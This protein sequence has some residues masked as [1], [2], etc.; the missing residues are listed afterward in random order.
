MSERS[1]RNGSSLSR[2]RFLEISLGAVVAGSLGCS[3]DDL[4]GNNSSIA[5]PKSSTHCSTG[6]TSLEELGEVVSTDVLI[7]GGG[8]GGLVA[9]VKAKETNPN[10]DVLIVEKQTTGWAGKASKIGGVVAFLGP[11]NDADKFL[12]FQIRTCGRY[13]NNQQLLTKYVQETYRAVAQLGDWGVALGRGQ[14]GGL[15]SLPNPFALEYSMGLIDIDLMLS[16]R[17]RALDLKARVLNKI[18]VTDLVKQADRIVGAVGFSILTGRFYTIK[19]KATVLANGSCGY[20]VRRFWVAGTGDGVAAAFRAGAEMRN[21]EY[22]NLYGHVVYQD[23]DSGMVDTTTLV[24]AQGEGL[25]SKYVSNTGPSGVFVPVELA[26]GLEKEVLEGKGPIYSAPL[27]SA[28][29]GE[30]NAGTGLPKITDWMQRMAAKEAKYGPPLD[31]KRAL[32]LPL[33]AETSCIKVDPEM[34]TSL[35]GLWAIGDTCHAGSSVAGAMAAP[36][37]VSPGSGIMF[38][39]VSAAWAGPSAAQYA[40]SVAASDLDTCAVG[41]LKESTFGPLQRTGGLLPEQAISTLQEVTA[42][43]KFSL[44]RSEERLTEAL[45]RIEEL[46]QRLPELQAKD[47]HYLSKCHEVKSMTVCAELTHR[48][49]LARTESRGFHY[50]EDH[51]ATD[52]ANWLKWVL[53]KETGGQMAVSTQP[54]PIDEYPLKPN[55]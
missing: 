28:A 30:A 4:E 8:I 42:P 49:A 38:A 11:N 25:L 54:I 18:H 32:A 6:P 48:A 23:T 9:A 29:G 21:A 39:V 1:E 43:M 7:I 51:P 33:H 55:T 17:A 19:A 47:L 53:L 14:D 46:K 3:E 22:G 2:R 15:L 10:L 45:G 31:A 36:P 16:I 27:A 37:G 24:N 44:R 13:L 35:E 26:L 40:A 12:D 34:K 20:K 50:R 41:S 52:N 5:G